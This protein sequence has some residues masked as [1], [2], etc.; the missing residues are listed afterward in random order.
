MENTKNIKS[1]YLKN[2]KRRF[3]QAFNNEIVEEE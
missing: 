2:R 3:M 1:R